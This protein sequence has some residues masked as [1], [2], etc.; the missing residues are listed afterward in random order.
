MRWSRRKDQSHVA[1]TDDTGIPNDVVEAA[2][3]AVEAELSSD[4]GTKRARSG[5]VVTTDYSDLEGDNDISLLLEDDPEKLKDV[6]IFDDW[7]GERREVSDSRAVQMRQLRRDGS[8]YLE[9]D[10]G[11]VDEHGKTTWRRIASED[12]DDPGAFRLYYG[13]MA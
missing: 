3:Y 9:L 11:F 5:L 4:S 8:R 12:P 1:S 7:W 10:E 13:N 6:R 2:K